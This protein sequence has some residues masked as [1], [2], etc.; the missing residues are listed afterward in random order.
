MIEQAKGRTT[1]FRE[2]AGLDRL[3]DED[4]IRRAPAVVAKCDKWVH[5]ITGKPAWMAET[6][7]VTFESMIDRWE[8]YTDALKRAS[9]TGGQSVAGS[10][11]GSVTMTW[12]GHVRK[13]PRLPGRDDQGRRVV[14]AN[15]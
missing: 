10:R 9:K 5:E 2:L 11:L 15:N 1:A 14:A 8:K 13:L 4:R 7:P 6:E 12:R 3:S